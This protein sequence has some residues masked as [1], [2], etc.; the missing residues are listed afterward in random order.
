MLAGVSRDAD[1]PSSSGFSAKS[2]KHS[3]KS[4]NKFHTNA[5]D[6]MHRPQLQYARKMDH[7]TRGQDGE[8]GA[9]RD[10]LV[11]IFGTEPLSLQTE[12]SASQ[13]Q[14]MDTS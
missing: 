10:A 6:S 7:Q 8:I 11:T 13:S 3:G 12:T 1:T 2:S 14:D 5:I 9:R 4:R